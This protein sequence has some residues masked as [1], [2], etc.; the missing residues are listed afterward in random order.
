MPHKRNPITHVEGYGMARA[1][2]VAMLNL[3]TSKA[4]WHERDI[5]PSSVG[6]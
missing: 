6:E 3:L 2:F 1:C 4:L 5:S